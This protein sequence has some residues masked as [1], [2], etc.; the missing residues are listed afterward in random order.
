MRRKD[1]EK[2]KEKDKKKKNK[3]QSDFYS[4]PMTTSKRTKYVGAS[5]VC[6]LVVAS[7]YGC[8]SHAFLNKH[9]DSLN[10]LICTLSKIIFE[11]N[12]LM[13]VWVFY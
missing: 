13:F 5:C 1:K 11:R 4:S 3:N 12:Q 2:E 8:K 6:K 10:T 7:F 9:L